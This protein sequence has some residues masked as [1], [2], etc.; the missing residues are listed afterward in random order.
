M[1]NKR[2]AEKALRQSQKRQQRNDNIRHSMYDIKRKIKKAVDEN[3]TEGLAELLKQAQEILD[4]AAKNNIIKKNAASRKKSSLTK[5]VNKKGTA[6]T[7]VVAKKTTKKTTAKKTVKKT[8]KKV[9]SK[10][11]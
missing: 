8:T 11:K 9:A 6:E 7:K 10:K 4:K 5:M 3:S 1:P 2:N